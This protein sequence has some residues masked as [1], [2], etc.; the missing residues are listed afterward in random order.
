MTF[1]IKIKYFF[2]LSKSESYKNSHGRV[3]VNNSLTWLMPFEKTF[4]LPFFFFCFVLFPFLLFVSVAPLFCNI[5]KIRFQMIWN[6]CYW[7]KM[8]LWSSIFSLSL[9]EFSIFG[10]SFSL[11]IVLF[12]FKC[13]LFFSFFLESFL[14]HFV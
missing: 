8:W 5:S 10:F 12:F 4:F 6:S 9:S 2:E 7:L 13:L 1:Y 3:S 14:F 11:I